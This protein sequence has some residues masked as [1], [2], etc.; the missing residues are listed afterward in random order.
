MLLSNFLKNNDVNESCVLVAYSG[1]TPAQLCKMD[2]CCIQ[3]PKKE[4]GSCQYESLC[5]K[6][7]GRQMNCVGED[8]SEGCLCLPTLV[9]EQYVLG[10]HICE[11]F[12]PNL[13]SPSSECAATPIQAA[14]SLLGCLV[15]AP[16]SVTFPEQ[17]HNFSQNLSIPIICS[18]ANFLQKQAQCLGDPSQEARHV[19]P[20]SPQ[21]ALPGVP[22]PHA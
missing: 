16:H 3:F 19:R 18:Q 20:S 14:S 8:T 4:F 1:S 17:G 7:P 5:L 22:S 12:F 15:F 11:C 13:Q 10:L 6:L 21:A 2:C 9:L